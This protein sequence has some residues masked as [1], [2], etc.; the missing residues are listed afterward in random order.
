MSLG[1]SCF[2]GIDAMPIKVMTIKVCILHRGKNYCMTNLLF[3][4]FGL[5]QTSKHVNFNISKVTESIQAKQEVSCTTIFPLAKY[6]LT[7]LIFSTSL[8]NGSSNFHKLAS[9]L[10]TRLNPFQRHSWFLFH[11]CVN[12][13]FTDK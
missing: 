10:L 4:W 7:H 11:C 6:F 5:N 8:E 9:I 2:W 12:A 3:G 13:P 1:K